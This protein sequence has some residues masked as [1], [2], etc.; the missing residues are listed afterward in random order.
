[1]IEHV[2]PRERQ[3]LFVSEAIRV[4]RRVF[5]TTPNRWFPIEV[6]TRLPVVH[7]LPDAVAHRAYDLAGK[8]YGKDN[9][10]LGPADLRALFPTP[11]RIVNLGM[12]LVA[13]T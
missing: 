5:V 3:A 12:T 2:G 4:A 1:M 6:H 9:L 10:L 8:G 11:V 13:M 7:W